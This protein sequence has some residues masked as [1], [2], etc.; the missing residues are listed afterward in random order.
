MNKPSNTNEQNESTQKS[1]VIATST[2]SIKLIAESIGI[3]NLTEEASRDLALD[4]TFTIKSI[5]AVFIF[6][7]KSNY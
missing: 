1:N 4:L 5:L 3:G 6:K 2:D 7:K